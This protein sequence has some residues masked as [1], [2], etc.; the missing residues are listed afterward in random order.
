MNMSQDETAGDLLRFARAW[1]ADPFR[2]AAI[3]P[4]S[5]SL[6]NLITSEITSSSSPIIELGAG[7]GSFT[8]A[9]IRRGV[10]E[11]QIHLIESDKEFAQLL[12]SRFPTAKV[13][14]IDAAELR[15]MTFDKSRPP[16]AAISGLPVVSMP[17][18]KVMMLLTALF[19][20]MRP[21]SALYQFTYG[22]R[23]PIARPILDRLGLKALKVSMTYRNLPPASVYRITQ[24]PAR[25]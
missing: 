24:R 7:T 20:K 22:P 19:E 5:Q 16:G 17:P 13:L 11:A 8:K 3:A 21:N 9:L 18:K 1:I 23:C 25:P 2:I 15:K 6:A 12:E 14:M 4:S 10:P